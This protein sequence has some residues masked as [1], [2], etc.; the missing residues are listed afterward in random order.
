MNKILQTPHNIYREGNSRLPEFD[1]FSLLDI[2]KRNNR[3]HG[4]RKTR[5]LKCRNRHSLTLSDLS[6]ILKQSGR[7]IAL[8][9]L[10]TLSISSLRNLDN[11]AS[12]SY[13]RAHRLYDTAILT[14]CYTQHA[15]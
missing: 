1:F 10:V 9:R 14:R 11:E 6:I 12:K 7:H 13:D 2:R 3:S 8:S 15:L 4:K 5:N